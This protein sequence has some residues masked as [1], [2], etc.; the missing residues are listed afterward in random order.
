MRRPINTLFVLF[1][2]VL[3]F[4]SLDLISA[5][6][7][8]ISQLYLEIKYDR[9]LFSPK[10]DITIMVDNNP[11]GTISYG[12]TFTKLLEVKHGKHKI[13][14]YKSR[15]KSVSVSD[16]ININEDCTVVYKIKGFQK[17]IGI[18]DTTITNS[19]SGAS[20]P[21]PNLIFLDLATA[22]KQLVQD[23]F[24]NINPK[25]YDNRPIV[26]DST[27]TVTDQNISAGSI[28]DKNDEIIL[29]CIPTDQ[30]LDTNFLGKT[31]TEAISTANEMNYSLDF[32]NPVTRIS[33]NNEV[34]KMNDD[35]KN[36]WFV[37][38]TKMEKTKERIVRLSIYYTG[39]VTVP[40]VTDLSLDQAL[41]IFKTN[42]FSNVK[43][44]AIDKSSIWNEKNWKVFYQS[45]SA[46]F[47][48]PA[49]KKIELVCISYTY[50]KTAI[51]S[52]ETITYSTPTPTLTPTKTRVPTSTP[53]PTPTKTRVPFTN[54][55]QIIPVKSLIEELKQ[56]S[57]RAASKYEG[58]IIR[59]TGYVK[60]LAFRGARGGIFFL[61]GDPKNYD[62]DFTVTFSSSQSSVFKNIQDGAKYTF[63]VTCETVG[64][65]SGFICRY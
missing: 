53:T 42:G 19:I 48:V 49:N 62:L 41:E 13:V 27:W 21:M 16:T 12:D 39:V 14:F 24:I 50:E 26:A 9:E 4:F 18:Q 44:K 29:T 22:K 8:D 6:A 51:A 25:A 58:R 20:I 38:E 31:I 47:K 7:V 56:D 63:T 28:I 37:S 65:Y 17:A 43:Y 23:G 46:G 35:E 30:F 61:V 40:D 33:V 57:E 10:Y 11:I 34:E 5:A 3:L 64:L 32:F 59:V 1:F 45:E 54:S 52:G 36:L 2:T 15:D 60:G 55:D